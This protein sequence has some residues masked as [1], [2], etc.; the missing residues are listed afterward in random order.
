MEMEVEVDDGS[1]QSYHIPP[2]TANNPMFKPN[3]RIMLHTGQ[4]ADLTFAPNTYS[5]NPILSQS[6]SLPRLVYSTFSSSR[7]SENLVSPVDAPNRFS[8]KPGED[9]DVYDLN[10]MD[11]VCCS[12]AGCCR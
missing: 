4:D 12:L 7:A 3:D 8:D 2:G 6:N 11:M 10:H 1:S 9:W 5:S